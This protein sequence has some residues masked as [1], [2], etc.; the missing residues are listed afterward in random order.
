L[1][2]LSRL[3]YKLTAKTKCKTK[4]SH[5]KG[6]GEYD[7]NP[8]FNP[9]N[10]MTLENYTNNTHK[11][12]Y[13]EGTTKLIEDKG[14]FVNKDA[15]IKNY[16]MEFKSSTTLGIIEP[17]N[18]EEILS[19]SNGNIEYCN[20]NNIFNKQ[21]TLIQL[22]LDL[23]WS[24]YVKSNMTTNESTSDKEQDLFS[25]SYFAKTAGQGLDMKQ[26]AAYKI[27]CC[28]YILKSI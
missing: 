19:D 5:C 17:Y 24:A 16:Y 3:P 23:S 4:D 10:L 13:T 1:K 11:Y 12:K 28:S 14:K 7:D 20:Y 15:A 27:M 21:E 9:D 25:L 6:H 22:I 26:T 2:K 8:D 18:Q